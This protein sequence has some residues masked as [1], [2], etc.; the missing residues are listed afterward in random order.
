L[1]PLDHLLRSG[2]SAVFKALP[3][4]WNAS[5]VEITSASLF[6]TK[7]VQE[8]LRRFSLTDIILSREEAEFGCMKVF[9]LEHGQALND[10][11]EEVFRDGIVERFMEDILRPYV[12]GGA[13]PNSLVVYHCS[14][15]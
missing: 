12:Y 11:A 6:M 1:T 13:G 3:T 10:S 15:N 5:E 4:S 7:I 9:M 2:D 8:A 14:L